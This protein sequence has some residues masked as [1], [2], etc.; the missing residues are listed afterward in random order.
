MLYHLT[1]FTE[2]VGDLHNCTEGQS[3]NIKLCSKEYKV[4]NIQDIRISSPQS[5][6]L[7]MTM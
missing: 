4:V 7:M 5:R 2:K 3:N 6:R 1:E